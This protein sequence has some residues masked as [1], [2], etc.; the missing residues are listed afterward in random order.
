MD[1]AH[2][3]I[4]LSF[5]PAH[6]LTHENIWQLVSSLAQSAEGFDIAENFIV[7]A[8]FQNLSICRS[9]ASI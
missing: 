6:D 7:F 4:G 5:R 9:R 2:G 1:L 3:L 8:R